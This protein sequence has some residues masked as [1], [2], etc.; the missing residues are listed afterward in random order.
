MPKPENLDLVLENF[1][2]NDDRIF[3]KFSY[4]AALG[5]P[6]SCFRMIPYD[7]HTLSNAILESFS[8]QRIVFCNAPDPLIQIARGFWS[9][10]YFH[11]L[12]AVFPSYLPIEFFPADARPFFTRTNTFFDGLLFFFRPGQF[13]IQQIAKPSFFFACKLWQLFK[14]FLKAHEI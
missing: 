10:G 7:L 4:A 8:S 13:R 1:V 2:V 12:E 11:G 6:T 5:V 3:D 14:D 9:G